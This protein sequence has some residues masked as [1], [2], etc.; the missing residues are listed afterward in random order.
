MEQFELED[1]LNKFVDKL[2]D[3]ITSDFINSNNLQKSEIMKDILAIN[4]CKQI[5]K[6]I[7]ESDVDYMRRV[8]DT[9]KAGRDLMN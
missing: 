8:Y 6:K 3:K 4:C 1:T 2:A 9:Y 7:D 5:T